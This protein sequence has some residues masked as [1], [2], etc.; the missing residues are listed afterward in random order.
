MSPD[1]RWSYLIALDEELLKGGVI[2]S[3]WCILIV[4]EA[5]TAFV[6]AAY[7][8]SILTSVSGIET[9]LQSEYAKTGRERLVELINLSTIPDALKANLHRLRKYRNKWVHIDDP[10]DDADLLDKPG[11]TENELEQM[12][13]FAV[14]ILRETIYE[15]Q[16]V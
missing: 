7:L 1:D 2:L 3:E 6:N 4:R 15:N 8:A 11:L 14:R 10:W 16:C 5:D 12:A 9:H 13:L